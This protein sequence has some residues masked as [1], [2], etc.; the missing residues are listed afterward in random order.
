MEIARRWS[1]QDF[2]NALQQA[3]LPEIDPKNLVVKQLTHFNRGNA[4]LHL[5]RPSEAREEFVKYREIAVQVGIDVME[6]VL[7]SQQA[8]AEGNQKT[9]VGNKKSAGTQK[10]N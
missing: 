2:L 8:S 6:T 3:S 5:D 10:K 4:L 9:V 7:S 1:H